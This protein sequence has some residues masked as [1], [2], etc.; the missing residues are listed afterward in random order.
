MTV[1]SNL[2]PTSITQ[3]PVAPNPTSSATMICVIGG[4]TYQVPFIDLQS[5]VSVPASRVIGTGGGLQGGGDLSQ[6]RTLSIA[7]GGVTNAKLANNGV[8]PGSYGS[9]TLIP[10]VT[11]DAKGLVTSVSTTALVISGYVPDT[12][13][14]IAGSGLTGGGNLQ[15][16]RTLAVNF[17]TAAPAALG[18]ASEGSAAASSRGDHVHPALNFAIGKVPVTPVVK[19]RPV[20]LVSV[21]L[22]GVP[23]AGVTNVGDVANTNAPL[24]VS[25][26][27]A[28]A[29]FA[30]VGVAKKVAT[31]VPKPVIEPTAGVTVVLAAKVNWPC[32][33]TVNVPTCVAEP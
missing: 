16:D 18:T 6:D 28:A 30:L 20:A 26:V 25:S 11:V 12:R 1:P 10:V 21:P 8:T 31:P 29:K 24:P 5:T 17:S 2:V 4:I 3:L 7:D 22:D 13:Q 32:A 19:G 33:F 14:I 23:R 15:A 9:G 27:T